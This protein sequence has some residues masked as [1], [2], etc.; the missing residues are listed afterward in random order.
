MDTVNQG[1]SCSDTLT[2]SSLVTF[3]IT[4]NYRI[5]DECSGTVLV[6]WTPFAS[7]T[8][9]MTISIPSE[10]QCILDPCNHY[11]TRVISIVGTFNSALQSVSGEY[12][13]RVKRLKHTFENE[14]IEGSGG[15]VVGGSDGGA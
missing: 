1:T 6:D 4:G 12:R 14:S 3:P 2:F 11:E 5:T 15:G 7:S 13:Y 10:V 9:T 8:S